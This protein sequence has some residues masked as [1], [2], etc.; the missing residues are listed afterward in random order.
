MEK[1][2][3]LM[4]K[5]DEIFGNIKILEEQINS[6]GEIDLSGITSQ[7][8][9]IESALQT[10]QSTVSSHTS[11]LSSHA[12]TLS[13]LSSSTSQ[14][15]TNIANNTQRLSYLHTTNYI[16]N[17]DFYIC[18]ASTASTFYSMGTEV[19]FVD[20]WL[21]GTTETGTIYYNYGTNL[22]HFCVGGYLKQPIPDEIKRILLGKKVTMSICTSGSVPSGVRMRL[23]MI[24]PS[25]PNGLWK[26]VQA[27]GSGDNV[28]H[29]TSFVFNE[30][31]TAASITIDSTTSET[32]VAINWV[33]LEV[34][35]DFTSY[36]SPIASIE[37]ARVTFTGESQWV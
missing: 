8:S 35:D 3:L 15:A 1:F 11:S 7:I 4:E 33:K 13:T 10:L 23:C 16:V 17:P 5:I 2:E 24:M 22:F 29:S 26:N 18:S 6:A 27:E 20:E 25:F 21:M 31:T 36:T 30:N 19:P 9:S 34:A 32:N 12:S 14:N 28:V 37:K